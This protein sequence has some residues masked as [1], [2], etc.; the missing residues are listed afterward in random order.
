MQLMAEFDIPCILDL[1]TDFLYGMT[2]QAFF[3]LKS[4]FAVVTCSAGL[5][6]FHL[7]HTGGLIPPRFI[8][9]GMTTPALIPRGVLLVAEDDMPRFFYSKSYIKNFMTFIAILDVKRFFPV[10]TKAAGFP[11]FHVC[12]GVICLFLDVKDGIVASLAIIVVDA[13]LADM[14]IMIEFY[15]AVI[16]AAKSDIFNV[17][18]IGGGKNKDDG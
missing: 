3:D 12:H 4:F 9:L 7:R 5:S 17:Y 14:K 11:L 2:P 8:K 15:L 10:V 16:T 18:G 6:L 1:E 13:F